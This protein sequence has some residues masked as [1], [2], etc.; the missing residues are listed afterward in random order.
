MSAA[1]PAK[2][3]KGQNGE[4]MTL[5]YF[6]C[7]NLRRRLTEMTNLSNQFGDLDTE[8]FPSRL[9]RGYEWSVLLWLLGYILLDRRYWYGY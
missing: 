7:S 3:E 8:N 5:W 1:Y 2:F 6:N 9:E 4:V